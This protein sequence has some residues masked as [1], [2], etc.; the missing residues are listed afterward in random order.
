M[1]PH[2]RHS[3]GPGDSLAAG[4]GRQKLKLRAIGYVNAR[5]GVNATPDLVHA[6]LTLLAETALEYYEALMGVAPKN[7]PA[8]PHLQLDDVVDVPEAK[9]ARQRLELAAIAYVNARHGMDADVGMSRMGL[10]LLTQAAI[11]YYEA[12]VI[13]TPKRQPIDPQRQIGNGA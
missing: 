4:H 2:A 3:A 6:G 8:D 11:E 7:R 12:L 1:L 10:A 13:A 5:H 9:R